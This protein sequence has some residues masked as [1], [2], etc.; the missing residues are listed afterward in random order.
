[1]CALYVVRAGNGVMSCKSAGGCSGILGDGEGEEVEGRGVPCSCLGS[2]TRINPV[3]T[4]SKQH[5]V[6][7]KFAN[8]V[9][10]RRSG[11]TRTS[12]E[13]SKF[14]LMPRVARAAYRATDACQSERRMNEYCKA[15]QCNCTNGMDMVHCRS[16]H[17]RNKCFFCFLIV[18]SHGMMVGG[19]D[20]L[21][22]NLGINIIISIL[23]IDQT[24]LSP[25]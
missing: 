24:K 5:N 1:M 25:L 11:T 3:G 9:M 13:K 19:K 7:G 22:I 18:L 10:E 23:G 15:Y 6:S 21:A 8:K 16:S 12:H 14:N 17:A 20:E 2:R 4:K